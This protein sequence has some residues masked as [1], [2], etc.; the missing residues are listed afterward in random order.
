M[1]LRKTDFALLRAIWH[2][3]GGGVDSDLHAH[4]TV[5]RLLKAKLIQWKPN[6]HKSNHA[7]NLLTF[8]AAGKALHNEVTS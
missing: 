5:Q 4:A 2:S 6:Q 8:T 3:N 1:I 7:A